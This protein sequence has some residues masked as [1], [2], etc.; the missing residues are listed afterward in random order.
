[1]RQLFMKKI[2]S[3]GLRILLLILISVVI[4]LSPSLAQTSRQ[5]T[6]YAY[7]GFDYALG[8]ELQGLNGGT[9]WSGSWTTNAGANLGGKIIPGLSYIDTDGNRLPVKGGALATDASVYFSQETRNTLQTFGTARKSVWLSFL[10][11]QSSKPLDGVNYAEATI[12]AGYTFGS[13]AMLG[14]ISADDIAVNPFYVGNTPEYTL[15]NIAQASSASLIVLR[16]DFA[17]NGNDTINLWVNPSLKNPGKPN[18]SGAFRNYAN[19]ISG[20]TLAHGDY[21][22]FVYDEVRIG[23]NYAAVVGN[24]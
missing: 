5:G 16:F 2:Y 12:G 15:A 24:I 17:S 21:R 23:S 19:P 3:K 6:L 20:V 8:S 13:N 1:M 18:I 4:A 9:G 11:K 10:V 7:D 14:G 22:T